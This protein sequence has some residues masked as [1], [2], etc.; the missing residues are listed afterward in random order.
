ML[1]INAEDQWHDREDHIPQKG[2]T[3]WQEAIL[4]ILCVAL[5]GFLVGLC[6][7][8]GA[9]VA[10]GIALLVMVGLLTIPLLT[11]QVRGFLRSVVFNG[12]SESCGCLRSC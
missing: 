5:L 10:Y 3:R 6:Y 7:R 2:L 11:R 12:S 1:R 4:C 9:P 8:T